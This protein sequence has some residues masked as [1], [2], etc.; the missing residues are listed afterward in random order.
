[1]R[2]SDWSSD[3]CS[4]DLIIAIVPEVFAGDADELAFDGHPQRQLGIDKLDELDVE[5]LALGRVDLER[6]R[7][8]QFVGLVGLPADLI[9]P[10]GP[11]GAACAIPD[12]GGKGGVASSEE[13]TSLLKSLM[14]I[15]SDCF[16]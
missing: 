7:V 9:R 5:G 16:S 13:H 12:G 3:V 8:D 14:R 10:S 11:F 2:I 15:S 1:M 4:S 6:G